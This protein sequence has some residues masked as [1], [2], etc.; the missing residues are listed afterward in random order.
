M[1]HKGNLS[2]NDESQM[3]LGY[4]ENIDRLEKREIECERRRQKQQSHREGEG[5]HEEISGYLLR[6]V[7]RSKHSYILRREARRK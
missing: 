6:L 1:A 2:R 5:E 7:K 4:Y 3:D